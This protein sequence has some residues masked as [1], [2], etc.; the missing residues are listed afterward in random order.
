MRMWDCFQS[1]LFGETN[2]GLK[3]YQNL[4]CICSKR[5]EAELKTYAILVHKGQFH[6]TISTE[7]EWLG[8][9]GYYVQGMVCYSDREFMKQPLIKSFKAN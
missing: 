7:Y 3:A 5:P 1:T 4:L 8:S 2:N 9:K 6:L